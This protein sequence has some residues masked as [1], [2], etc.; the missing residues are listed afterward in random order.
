MTT[1]IAI[2]TAASSG[3]SIK[4]YADRIGMLLFAESHK[5]LFIFTEH[6]EQVDANEEKRRWKLPQGMLDKPSDKPGHDA[7]SLMRTR[8]NMDAQE[9]GIWEVRMTPL[10]DSLPE[11]QIERKRFRNTLTT[12]VS[13][14]YYG[15]IDS[16]VTFPRRCKWVH[17]DDILNECQAFK[18]ANY[19]EVLKLLDERRSTLSTTN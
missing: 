17:V 7:R 18:V 9:F 4:D 15:R 1:S 2:H 6:V 5:G 14:H 11:T 13:A 19:A 8:F 10:Q 12:W 3:L 16:W